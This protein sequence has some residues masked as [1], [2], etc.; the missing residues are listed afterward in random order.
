MF[1]NSARVFSPTAAQ[2]AVQTLTSVRSTVSTV[3]TAST[4]HTFDG[5]TPRSSRSEFMYEL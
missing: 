3:S 5:P 1:C 4:L 2:H